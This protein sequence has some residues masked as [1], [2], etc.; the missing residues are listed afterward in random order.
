M[1]KRKAWI[2][3]F[4]GSALFWG[5]VGLVVGKAMAKPPK[6]AV[7]VPVFTLECKNIG[8]AVLMENGTLA[9]NGKVYKLSYGYMNKLIFNN[10]LMLEGEIN[11]EAIYFDQSNITINGERYPCRIKGID[12]SVTY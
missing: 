7:R 3:V 11:G 2:V 9:V 5:G 12:R 4:L 10:G 8:D 1:T 6:D